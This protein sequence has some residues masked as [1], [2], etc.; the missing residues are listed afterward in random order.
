VNDIFG[1][2]DQIEMPPDRHEKM[3]DD[4]L[5]YLDDIGDHHGL[6]DWAFGFLLD[7]DERKQEHRLTLSRR[8]REQIERL[9]D[10]NCD[11]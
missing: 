4:L 2:M 1:K 9:W 5:A 7:L 6:S 3:L 8:Q 10:E 11:F